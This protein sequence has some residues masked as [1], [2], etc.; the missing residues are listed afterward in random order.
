MTPRGGEIYVAIALTLSVR[1]GLQF[2]AC[3][4]DKTAHIGILL[5]I[6]IYVLVIVVCA[7]TVCVIFFTN[8]QLL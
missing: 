3:R 8:E 6:V 4:K 1:C 5:E 7:H 2:C